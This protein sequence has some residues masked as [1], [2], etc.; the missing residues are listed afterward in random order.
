MTRKE[1][2]AVITVVS[3]RIWRYVTDRPFLEVRKEV[4]RDLDLLPTRDFM[5]KYVDQIHA[6][7]TQTHP[8]KASQ[9]TRRQRRHVS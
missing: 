7:A 5:S 6:G 1:R 3:V 2:D 9:L 8:S 4:E